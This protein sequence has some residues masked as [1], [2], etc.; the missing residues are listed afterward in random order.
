[1]RK[2]LR[3]MEHKT[4][5][6]AIKKDDQKALQTLFE[7]YYSPLCTYVNNFTNNLDL[8]E[9]IVQTSFRKKL[10]IQKKHITITFNTCVKTKK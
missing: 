2:F 8:T 9:D 5:I 10:F 7:K 6:D 3:L 4:I 1:M